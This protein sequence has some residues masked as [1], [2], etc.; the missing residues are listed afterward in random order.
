MIEY[1]T[2]DAT[3]PTTRPAIVAHVCND[4]GAWGSGFVLAVSRRWKRPEKVYRSTGEL[5][6]GEVQFVECEE[7]IVV[8]NMVAQRG[9]SGPGPLVHYPALG[10]CLA[11]VAVRAREM[12][13]SIAMPRIGCG[14]GG[15]SWGEVE[16][17]IERTCVGV[18]VVVYD[19]PAA[20]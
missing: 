10:E 2:G 7:G 16:P 14:I 3:R 6:L 8:A 11:A 4:L 15:G 18:R 9:V 19:L 17:I 12:G 1:T 5:H 13:A 20:S